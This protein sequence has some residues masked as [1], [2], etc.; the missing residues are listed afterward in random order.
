MH[1]HFRRKFKSKN[2]LVKFTREFRD[3]LQIEARRIPQIKFSDQER[4]L[5]LTSKRNM[6]LFG[7]KED[8][9]DLMVTGSDRPDELRRL[10]DFLNRIYAFLELSTPAIKLLGVSYSKEFPVSGRLMGKYFEKTALAEFNSRSGLFLN[11]YG[12]VLGTKGKEKSLLMVLG[13]DEENDRTEVDITE[14]WN[15][16][17][18]EQSDILSKRNYSL[19][20]Q[21]SQ[22][23]AGLGVKSK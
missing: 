1:V 20:S 15:D 19:E 6:I 12:V 4:V 14:I 8:F 11:P 5:V 7:M 9:M 3:Y 10:D 18:P 2:S 16:I 17:R 22:I 23:F 21:K 13:Y